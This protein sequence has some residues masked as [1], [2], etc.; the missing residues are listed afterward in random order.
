[1]RPY[2]KELLQTSSSSFPNLRMEAKLDPNGNG[3]VPLIILF[4]MQVLMESEE[5]PKKFA[6]LD[7]RNSFETHTE[8]TISDFNEGL[9][10]RMTLKRRKEHVIKEKYIRLYRTIGKIRK[11]ECENEPRLVKNNKMTF[12]MC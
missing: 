2:N 9:I 8:E 4:E 1:M 6:A 10:A 5:R 12:Q 7:L 3:K 11:H